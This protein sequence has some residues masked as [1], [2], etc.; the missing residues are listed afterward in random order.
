MSKEVSAHRGPESLAEICVTAL[1]KCLSL[2]NV[3]PLMEI[4]QQA[5]FISDYLHKESL[6]FL[7]STFDVV[8][9]QEGPETVQHALA[10]DSL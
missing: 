10:D 9:E 5:D 2:S 6:K 4:C 8:L 3:L 7:I 1:K